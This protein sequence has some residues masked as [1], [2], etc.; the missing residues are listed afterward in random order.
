ME[1][2]LQ[3]DLFQHAFR[4]IKE[5]SD[6]ELFIH[7]YFSRPAKMN[8]YKINHRNK[9]PM[10][11]P[12]NVQFSRQIKSAGRLKE[13]NFRKQAGI[14]GQLY[15]IDVS[16]ERGN[17]FSFSMH[18]LQGQW[19]IRETSIAGWIL[20]A[21]PLLHDAIENQDLYNPEA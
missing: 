1:R 14:E 3:K 7:Q 9:V 17:R 12:K 20:E 10:I 5:T 13:F 21:E 15:G 4:G 8:L 16:D 11:V 18:E 6:Q 19:K 2:C